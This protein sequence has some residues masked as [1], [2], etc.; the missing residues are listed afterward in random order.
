MGA[1]KLL[2]TSQWVAGLSQLFIATKLFSVDLTIIFTKKMWSQ[3]KPT[4][5]AIMIELKK[6]FLAAIKSTKKLS[7]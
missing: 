6:K 7:I 1:N 5:N 3:F 2:V 4:T